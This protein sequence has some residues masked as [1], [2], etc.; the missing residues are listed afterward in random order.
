MPSH[1]FRVHG[2]GSG[3]ADW[4]HGPVDFASRRIDPYRSRA[5]GDGGLAMGKVAF[6]EDLLELAVLRRAEGEPARSAWE[7]ILAEILGPDASA[8]AFNVGG[9]ALASLTLAAQLLR[10]AR[11]P[12]TYY[13]ASG[14]DAE[15]ARIRHTLAQTPLDM[16]CFRR[17]PGRTTSAH[18][19]PDPKAGGGAGDRFF[20]HCQGADSPL[21][22]VFQ[23]ET[24]FQAVFNV[25]AGTAQVP[26]LHRALP[27]L[28]GK[29]RRRGALTIVGT[30][31]DHAAEK[32][33]PGRPW[34]MGERGGEAGGRGI[35]PDV[36]LLVADAAELSGLAGLPGSRPSIASAAS[37]EDAS[38]IEDGVQSL[39]DRGLSAA[40]VTRGE[41]RVYYRSLGGPFGECRGWAEPHPGLIAEARDPRNMGDTSGAGD[42]FLGAL[43]ADLMH[44]LL[45]DDF[46]PKGEPHVDRELLSISPLRLRRA[47]DFACVAGGLACQQRGG[48]RLEAAPG[49]NLGRIRAYLP[50]PMPAGRP[51]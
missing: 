34:P 18:V 46:Y 44:Q 40:V 48:V 3:L 2:A 25:Y 35:W 39:F 36:D 17:R 24:F 7:E 26:A 32:T 27:S 49:E 9:P 1:A 8:P 31:Y 12:V 29:S 23:G 19:F 37:L 4:I 20:V 30:V 16:T 47:I 45:A 42:N 21:E 6:R 22:D 15:A 28:L 50:K 51:W 38:W 5:L 11:V 43:V 14:D 41:G 10:P 33:A 13:G